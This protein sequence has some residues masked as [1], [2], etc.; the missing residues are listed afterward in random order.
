MT[1]LPR[2]SMRVLVRSTSRMMCPAA[3]WMMMSWPAPRPLW[4]AR[5]SWAGATVSSVWPGEDQLARSHLL[6]PFAV[7]HDRRLFDLLDPVL[8]HLRQQLVDQLVV[9]QLA[10]IG[11]HILQLSHGHRRV[12]LHSL[13]SLSTI[14]QREGADGRDSGGCGLCWGDWLLLG[15]GLG[16]GVCPAKSIDNTCTESSVKGR[17]SKY[18]W[19]CS[20]IAINWETRLSLIWERSESMSSMYGAMQE[21]KPES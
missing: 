6:R 14:Y 13:L 8:L 9:H 4:R 21:K 10:L 16:R 20:Q 15:M 3:M 1:I 7:L 19:C 17:V 5:I 12:C 18:N 2:S 11:S